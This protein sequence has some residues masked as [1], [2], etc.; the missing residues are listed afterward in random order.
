MLPSALNAFTA[1][2]GWFIVNSVSGLTCAD[3]WPASR[4]RGWPGLFTAAGDVALA[5]VTVEEV[6]HASFVFARVL[7]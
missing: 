2:V 1:G 5:E 4:A 3:V 6:D 7:A